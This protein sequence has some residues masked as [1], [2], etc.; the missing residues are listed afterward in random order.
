MKGKVNTFLY[1]LASRL[2]ITAAEKTLVLLFGGLLILVSGSRQVLSAVEQPGYGST[3][4]DDRVALFQQRA[5]RVREELS[6]LQEQYYPGERIAELS[7]DVMA[8]TNRYPGVSET[9]DTKPPA[10]AV[11]PQPTEQQTA[12][13]SQE[14][15]VNINTATSAQLES[16]P[17]IGPAIAARIIEHRNTNGSFERIEDIKNVRGIAEGRF[18]AIADLITT[19][20]EKE[21]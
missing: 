3:D 5:E 15:K 17:G 16:L 14:E 2:Q 18:E 9:M 6:A 19:G 20:K 8:E 21:D 7:T 4:Y 12:P 11:A 10:V 1:F 13:G